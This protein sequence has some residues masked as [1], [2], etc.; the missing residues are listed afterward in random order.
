[1]EAKGKARCGCARCFSIL[2]GA[3][4]ARHHVATLSL[5]NNSEKGAIDDHAP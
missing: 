3:L 4:L 5:G 1:M 2:H